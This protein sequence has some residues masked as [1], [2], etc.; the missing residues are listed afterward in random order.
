MKGLK[1]KDKELIDY[2]FNYCR[3]TTKQLAKALHLPQ[4]TI[5]YKIR[6]LEE[7]NYIKRYD[8]V[9]N[10]NNIDLIKKIYFLKKT[11]EELL[12][13]LK[14]EKSVHSIVESIGTHELSVW[15]FFKDEK[16][17]QA[18]EEEYEFSKSINVKKVISSE[19]SLFGTKIKLKKPLMKEKKIKLDNNDVKLIKHLSTGHA[20]DSILKISKDL[21]ISYDIIHY[22]LKNLIKN[23][24]FSR[25][26]PQSGEGLGAAKTTLLL[27]ELKEVKE[28]NINKIKN[29][30]FLTMGGY[31]DKEIYL[32][33][34]SSEQDD[35]LE[36]LEKIY[37]AVRK[38]LLSSEAMHWKQVYKL[39]EYPLEYLTK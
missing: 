37:H 8:A 23:K 5:S 27:V 34:L 39:N 4:Q 25:L 7:Q 14:K 17:K 19:P 29:L 2:L 31:N 13:K 38:E 30:D 10:W 28:E 18:F 20:R 12:T 24:Y 26:I 11:E 35:Y 3:Y 16:Q 1:N 32:H 15:C 36:K 9:L 6:R 21:N 22:R 33:I